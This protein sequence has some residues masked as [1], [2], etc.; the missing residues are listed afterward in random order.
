MFPIGVQIYSVR[1]Y[2]EKDLF[3]TL[4]AI[5]EMGYDGVEFA[6]L[7]G[8]E[9]KQIKAWL[10]ELD[11]KA[12]SAH[13][14]IEEML[15]NPDKVFSDYKEIGCEY[16]AIPYLA[17]E[18]RMGAEG[19]EKTLNEMK[20]LAEKANAHG[21]VFMYHNHDFE[22][23]K[24]DG[25]YAFDIMY[26]AIPASLLQ[27]EQDTCWVNVSGENP[28]EYIRKYS[29]RCPV[30]H[31]K[32]FVMKNREAKSGLY[33]L[34]GIKPTETQADEGDFAF[35]PAGYGVQNCP[36]I[37]E[38]SKEAGS[39]WLVVEQDRPCLGWTSMECIKKAVDY[40]KSI[41]K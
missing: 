27:A 4:K 20:M 21:L 3:A 17:P 32:D 23:A 16:I 38:A 5:K 25:K 40:L 36:E 6:G 28:A 35:R 13:V 34:I 9:P 2:A 11:L 26:D 29:G 31:I 24:F 22:F 33:E 8:Y 18:R 39:K 37:L 19:F 1:D 15:E 14:A 10:D 7:Y 12:V 30:V 41:N